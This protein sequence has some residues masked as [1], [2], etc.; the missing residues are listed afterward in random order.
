MISFSDNVVSIDSQQIEMEHTVAAVTEYEGRVV[1]LL[2]PDAYTEKFAQFENLIAFSR[3]GK[4]LWTAELATTNSGDRY[5]KV[6]GGPAL[7]AWSVY[8]F[9]CEID[10]ETGRVLSRE[11]VK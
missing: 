8:S 1:V 4:K 7:Q 11:F 9:I 2:D 6:A 3:E 10:V 5:Y